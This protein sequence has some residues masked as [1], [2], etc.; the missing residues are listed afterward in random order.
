MTI[1]LWTIKLMGP[2]RVSR[3]EQVFTRFRTQKTGSLLAYLAAY[4]RPARRDQL[5]EMLWPDN[6][7]ESGRNCLRIALS[8]LRRIFEPEG[9]ENSLF[10][11][12]LMADRTHVSLN[13]VAFTTD[14]AAFES[15]LLNATRAKDETTR[16]EWLK[17][18]L[19]VYQDDLL[20]AYDE[21]WIRQERQRLKDARLLAF[22]R[23]V[24]LVAKH[25]LPTAFEYA[26]RAVEADPVQEE[27]QRM[28]IQLYAYTGQRAAALQQYETMERLLR[29]M[30]AVPSPQTRKIIAEMD[31][32]LAPAAS[33]RSVTPSLP[34]NSP[35]ANSLPSNSAPSNS[36]PPSSATRFAPGVSTRAPRLPIPPSRFFGHED[37]VAQV[38]EMLDTPHTR[39]ITLTG[40]GG[41]GKTRLALAV[42][43]K[44]RDSLDGAVWFVPLAHVSDP[45]H[46]LDAVIEAMSLPRQNHLGLAEQVAHALGTMPA[47]L[48]LDNYEH[49]AEQGA[50]AVLHLLEAVPGLLCLV[51]SRQRLN[52]MGEYEYAVEP[53]PTPLSAGTPERLLEFASVQ[54]FL[55]R[56]QAVRPQFRLTRDNAAAIA[57]ICHYLEG[58]PL[59]IELAAA[60]AQ[61]LTP[62]QIRANLSQRLSLRNRNCDAPERHASLR[63]ALEGSYRLL[64]PSMQRFFARLSVLRG[65]WTLEAA[66]AIC[67][68]ANDASSSFLPPPSAFPALPNALECLMQMRERSLVQA[69]EDAQIMRYQ[70]METLRE[71]AAEQIAGEEW[72]ETQWRHSRY[73]LRLAEEAEPHLTGPATVEWLNRLRDEH[74][75]LRAALTFLLTAD[76]L[77]AASDCEGLRL[78]ASL[79]RFWYVRGC[80]EEGQEW[81]QR[82]LLAYPQAPPSLRLKALQG[83]GSLAY[84]RGEMALAQ[85]LFE[86]HLA[87][88]KAQGDTAATAVALGSLG[89]VSRAQGDLEQARSLREDSLALFRQVDDRRGIAVSLAN[90]ANVLA[91]QQE[92]NEARRLI[93]ESLDVFR[94][95][96]DS[97]SVV[98]TLKNLAMTSLMLGEP[99]AARNYLL[100]S[101]ELA[102]VLENKMGFAQALI[103]LAMLAGSRQRSRE[104]ATLLGCVEYLLEQMQTCLPTH[105]RD[106]FDQESAALRDTLGD[107]AFTTAWLSG[108]ALPFEQAARMSHSL[109]EILK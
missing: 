86:E 26:H 77:S 84:E 19:D 8:A 22:R 17:K 100:E 99:N 102:R 80:Y 24:G 46:I 53:L 1:D 2:L 90:L 91:A 41:S 75:N 54:L 87:L 64:E 97:H 109:L 95:L 73:F 27:S 47:L 81:L 68:D 44:L 52:L 72:I 28:L 48:I 12:V 13:Q 69:D 29:E 42:G 59:A 61:T 25:D 82:A 11:T 88:A 43:E 63:A 67:A 9:Q 103:V 6:D 98:M 96:K 49:L 50:K 104:A 16:I 33:S 4:P 107:D 78:A 71:Y 74:D 5:I 94:A 89:N 105:A 15:G 65:G 37:S 57:D 34:A 21:A 101:V 66:Q 14:K 7:P 38:V 62:L 93:L 56:A 35:L 10:P 85:T 55:D 45:R 20:P 79:W 3:G 108:R 58:V 36:L 31:A 60:Y 83:T 23:L 92:L 30:D 18:A 76:A 70:M 51:T 40:L 39:L 32:V 106:E